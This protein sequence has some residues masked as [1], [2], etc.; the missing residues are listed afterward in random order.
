M[1]LIF[2]YCPQNRYSMNALIAAAEKDEKLKKSNFFV[3]EKKGKLIKTLKKCTKT[4]Q[5]SFLLFS[6]FTPQL[7]EVKKLIG[8]I[9]RTVGDKII[10]I[11]GGSH[12]TGDPKGTLE[13]GFDFVVH[14]EGEK[15]FPELI[16]SIKNG[17][18]KDQIK[19][20]SFFDDHNRYIYTGQRSYLDL[21]KYPPFPLEHTNYGP[22]EIT[23]GCPYMCYFCQT[24]FLCGKKP[25]HR[26]IE[27][28]CKYITILENENLTDIRFITPNA[29][30]YGSKD[31]KELNL[32]KVEEL[33]KRVKKIIGESGRIFFGSFPSE[34]RPEH[35]CKKTLALI[36]KYGDNDNIIIGAQSGSQK[37]LDLCN[38][39]HTVENIYEAVKITN[40]M[41]LQANIDFIFGLPPEKT[42]D[43]KQTIHVME[44]LIKLGGRIHA[45]TFIPL[46]QTPFET[47]KASKLDKNLKKKLQNINYHGNLYGNWRKQ[48]KLA[49]KISEYFRKKNN[50]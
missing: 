16:K 44:D 47:K 14:G 5:E 6:F 3:I 38:R 28:I 30:A 37:I 1:N 29:F 2:Y 42:E 36:K 45:H 39:G 19:G 17:K 43:I 11:A 24:S 40:K 10:A 34:V 20:I 33:L 48:E 15:T 21:D 46:P 26:S 25:R 35:V 7:W 9:K 49:L 13:M 50:G 32:E 23:R 31:G 27:E 22:I 12:P 8:K 41:G 18:E 4:S